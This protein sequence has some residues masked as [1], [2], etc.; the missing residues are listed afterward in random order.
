LFL[1]YH[2]L[3]NNRAV[4][5][6]QEVKTSFDA[7]R[8]WFYFPLFSFFEQN[9]DGRIPNEFELPIS[10]QDVRNLVKRIGDNFKHK[11]DDCSSN[12]KMIKKRR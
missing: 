12:K 1:Y 4:S 5:K 6:Y 10:P 8:T 2:T 11:Y 3:V 9:I 7:K